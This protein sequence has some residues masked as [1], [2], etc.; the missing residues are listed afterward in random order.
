MQLQEIRTLVD[1]SVIANWHKIEGNLVERW[2]QGQDASQQNYLHP[3]CHDALA[4]FKP[5]IAVSL[6]W[7]AT[8]NSKFSE[9][10]HADLPDSSANAV[11]VVLR[12]NGAKVDEWTFVIVDGGRYILPLPRLSNGMYEIPTHM[13][14]LGRLIFSLYA[15]GGVHNSLDDLLAQCEITVV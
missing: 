1:T 13:M 3:I 2:D 14:A 11:L 12:H 10:W 6:A 8:I 15:P 9:S 7:G 5:N 4:V